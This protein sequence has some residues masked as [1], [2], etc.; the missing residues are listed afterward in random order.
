MVLTYKASW[1]SPSLYGY[2]INFQCMQKLS[3][4]QTAALAGDGEMWS[5]RHKGVG[6]VTVQQMLRSKRP[7]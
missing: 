6:V 1:L 2:T 5:E 4:K 7:E 3:V